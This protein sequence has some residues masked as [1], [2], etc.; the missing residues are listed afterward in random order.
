M[1]VPSDSPDIESDVWGSCELRL[2]VRGVIAVG[3]WKVINGRRSGGY[4]KT[5]GLEG[6]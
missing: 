4:G 6:V 1:W 5:L 2:L 3:L